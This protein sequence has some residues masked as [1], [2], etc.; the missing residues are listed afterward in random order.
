MFNAFGLGFKV[1]DIHA[2]QHHGLSQ[3]VPSLG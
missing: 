3:F 1:F 2:S